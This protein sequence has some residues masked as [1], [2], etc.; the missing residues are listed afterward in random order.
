MPAAPDKAWDGRPLRSRCS[1]TVR[2]ERR[3]SHCG[4]GPPG[5][6]APSVAGDTGEDLRPLF[7]PVFPFGRWFD[8]LQK[9]STQLKTNLTSATKNRADKV[10]GGGRLGSLGMRL[11]ASQVGGFKFSV[12]E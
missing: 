3:G 7:A 5:P 8:V 9:V 6:L 12:E 2:V 1:P 11:G 10:R 4:R